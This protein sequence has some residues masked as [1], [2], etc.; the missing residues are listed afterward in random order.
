MAQKWDRAERLGLD[1]ER[2]TTRPAGLFPDPLQKRNPPECGSVG[3]PISETPALA[4]THPLQLPPGVEL[5][6]PARVEDGAA[7]ASMQPDQL[8]EGIRAAAA[9]LGFHAT[10]FTSVARLDEDAG[11]L[12]CWLSRGFHGDMDYLASEADRADPVALLPGAA[13]MLVVAL[14]HAPPRSQS[15]SNDP[16]IASFA[17]G[18]D[19]HAVMKKKLS[20]LAQACADLSGRPVRARACVDTAPV[21]ERAAARRA[22]VGFI[23]RNTMLIVPGWGS[24]VTLGLLVLDLPL[25]PDHPLALSC[26]ECDA[27]MRACPTGALVEPFTVDARRCISYLTIESSAPIPKPLRPLLGQRLFGCDACQEACPYNVAPPACGRAPPRSASASAWEPTRLLALGS[28]AHRRLV[29][30]TALQ[31]VSRNRLAR[32]AAVAL[33]NHPCP[34]AADALARALQQHPSAMVRAHAAWALGRQPGAPYRSVLEQAAATDADALV[35]AEASDAL[36]HNGSARG[37]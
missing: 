1:P 17:L 9:R 34:A 11:R 3:C 29:R 35:R 14:A 2:K 36:D 18:P 33:G 31:R 22:G 10:G 20:A 25:P 16:P 28:S 23:G 8:R 27:C 21:L 24:H 15:T 4:V 5:H 12:T 7:E 30:G 37:R 6:L 13:S 32:N 26:H 19:Y